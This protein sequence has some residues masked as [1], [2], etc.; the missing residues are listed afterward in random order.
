MKTKPMAHQ[1]EALRRMNSREFYGLFMEM[2]TGKT[3]TFLADAERL[4]AAGSI[5]GVIIIAPK[6][7][8]TN[9][10]LR[11]IPIHLEVDHIAV[12]YRSGAG[13]RERARMER[14]FKPREEGDPPAL[15]ILSINIDALNYKSG[16]EFAMRFINSV[17]SVLTVVDESDTIKNPKSGRTKAVMRIGH[18]SAFRRIGTGTPTPNSP[19]DVFSQMQ[20]L[21]EGLLGTNS[22]S[23]FTAE[24]AQLLPPEHR[25]VKHIKERNRLNFDPQV[26]ATDARGNPIWRNLDK[27]KALL[28]PHTFRV[29]KKDCLD[30]PPKVY[31]NVYFDLEPSQRAEYDRL[32]NELRIDIGEQTEAF[33]GNALMKLQQITSGFIMLNGEA[34]GLNSRANPRLDALRDLLPLICGQFIVWARF[35]EELRTIAAM[36]TDESIS[37]VEYRGETSDKDRE[38]AV[39]KFQSGE[40]RGF[41]GQ[42]QS[43]GV[44]IPLFA[45]TT[46][47]YYSNDFNLRTRL[48]S[49]DRAHRKGT[50]SSVLYIDIV[51]EN[52]VDISIASALQ[53]KQSVSRQIHDDR[54]I[55][56]RLGEGD[57]S[58]LEKGLF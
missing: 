46:V 32:E 13:K 40:V 52:T 30:L 33:T 16:M 12:A 50:V 57:N 49:E 42:P 35:T 14:L 3:W 23:A 9:W 22:A 6:G 17:R 41:V 8:H 5:D 10:V 26:V 48:Q 15:R 31:K 54:G 18:H 7:V 1:A 24:F 58:T 36:L 39:D 34:H 29:L 37:F 25:L 28:Q 53:H 4:F 21:R 27:L 45:A 56:L 47:I 38:L 51:A 43:G 20:F 55:A 19:I 44:G 2:G 11:E